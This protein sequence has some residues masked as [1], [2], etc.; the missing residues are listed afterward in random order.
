MGFGVKTDYATG[1]QID[2][3]KSYKCLIKP[4]LSEKGI[5]CVR[6]DDIIHSGS[7]DAVMYQELLTADLVIADLSTANPNALYELGIRHAL[8]PFTTIVISESKLSYPFDLNHI[9]ITSYTILEGGIDFEEVIRFREKLG[10]LIDSVLAKQ[11]PD[12]PV[13]TY[14]SDLDP[15]SLRAEVEKAI[16]EAGKALED[17][18][19]ALKEAASDSSAANDQDRTLAFLV[20]QGEKAID[21]SDFVKAKVNFTCALELCSKG[22]VNPVEPQDRY[23]IHRLVLA[24][25]KT[26]QPN[27]VLALNEASV[28]LEPLNP[29]ESNDPETVGLA[30]AIEKRLYELGRGNDHLSRSIRYY[31]RGYLLKEDRYNGINLSYLLNLRAV[32]SIYSEKQEKLAD[33]VWAGRVR[34][35]IIPLCEQSLATIQKHLDHSQNNVDSDTGQSLTKLQE[36]QFWC[37]AT[38]A[39][40]H[41][42][43]GDKQTYTTI[44]DRMKQLNTAK[45]MMESFQDQINKLDK[46]LVK[47]KDILQT[48]N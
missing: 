18:G 24:T 37:L 29:K 35:E 5:V 17:A 34:K 2:L 23:L 31:E 33:M 36:E 13:Y 43:L 8:R 1:R 9:L 22:G 30:G 12:S 39:E 14:L 21:D 28:L 26:K 47:T 45:W 44:R 27:A 46:L 42:G 25:Y 32:S 20:E 48:S 40:A 11:A 3:N 19:N 6:A 4:V 38:K 10:D 15:P 16:A 7:I 41:F